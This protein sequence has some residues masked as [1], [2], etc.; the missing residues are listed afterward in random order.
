M[1]EI[2]GPF[3]DNAGDRLY[4]A[5]QLAAMWGKMSSSDGVVTGSLNSLA[6]GWSAGYFMTIDSGYA[7]KAGQQYNNT[8]IMSLALATVATT[9]KRIDL[10]V[11]RFDNTTNRS[12]NAIIIQGTPTTG[13]PTAPSS[14]AGTDVV[15]GQILIDNTSGT[16]TF[17]VTD[18]RQIFNMNNLF[19]LVIDSNAKLDLW[20][21]CTTG[22]FKRVL[23]RAGTWT[24]SALGQSGTGSALIDLDKAGTVY[25]FAE[26]G[27]SINYSA[28]FAGF[29][30]GLYH[31]T[32]TTDMNVERFENVKIVLTNTNT[33]G[34]NGVLGGFNKC[35]N[36][37]NCIA[38]SNS[39]G[40]AQDQGFFNCINLVDCSSTCTCTNIN[41]HG[42]SGCNRLINCDASSPSGGNCFSGCNYLTNCIGVGVDSA[43][44]SCTYLTNCNGT[45]T[46]AA[47]ASSTFTGCSSLTNCIGVA[48]GGGGNAGSAFYNCTGLTLCSGQGL[49]PG[50]GPGYGFN[51]CHKMQ[52][53]KAGA[54][55]K[56][57]TYNASYA[58]AGS[59][60]ACAD[61]AAGGYNS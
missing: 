24:A 47:G 25:V 14:V 36:L 9:Y 28:N 22:Q 41:T 38:I 49:N 56:T 55:S 5:Q 46:S 54:A 33:G 37:I 19:D 20:C 59:G 12:A 23:I 60:N 42:F 32:L 2:S 8:A 6:P 1:S 34:S 26:K 11:V 21:A 35:S 53:N 16:P 27:S 4:T 29:I 18:L 15:I 3:T 45:S 44:D 43:F 10:L 57:A 61:T 58:D 52:Q 51:G 31:A 50:A 17:T 39:S 30:Y 7:Y 40:S 13:T 48:T